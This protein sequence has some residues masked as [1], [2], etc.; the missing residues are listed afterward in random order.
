VRARLVVT[1][2]LCALVDAIGADFACGQSSDRKINMEAN[3]CLETISENVLINH[4]R[5]K[6]E[7]G[8]ISFT[9]LP[10]VQP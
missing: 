8:P 5:N 6:V 2:L 1:S 3:V 7:I 10:R 9:F 4:S